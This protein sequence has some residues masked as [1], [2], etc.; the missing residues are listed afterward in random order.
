M[1]KKGRNSRPTCSLRFTEEERKR[2]EGED[3]EGR[4]KPERFTSRGKYCAPSTEIRP[5]DDIGW[6]T[7]Q[8]YTAVRKMQSHAKAFS[9]VRTRGKA[10]VKKEQVSLLPP[11]FIGRMLGIL[12]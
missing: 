11:T 10:T 5:V 1:R 7:S 8:T 3:P 4:Q 2:T 9:R 12:V 6:L